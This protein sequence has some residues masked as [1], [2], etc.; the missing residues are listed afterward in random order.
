MRFRFLHRLVGYR[1]AGLVPKEEMG[2]I[3][4]RLKREVPDFGERIARMDNARGGQWTLDFSLASMKRRQFLSLWEIEGYFGTLK[5]TILKGEN[6]IFDNDP[7]FEFCGFGSEWEVTQYR[8]VLPVFD[9]ALKDAR[10]AVARLRAHDSILSE[11]D[12]ATKQLWIAGFSAVGSVASAIAAGF[13]AYVAF[14]SL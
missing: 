1:H 14:K 4:V 5:G 3:L 12:V 13:A 2:R 6:R 7:D 11:M 8:E 10:A 9:A